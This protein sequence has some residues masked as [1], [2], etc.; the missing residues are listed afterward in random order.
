MAAMEFLMSPITWIVVAI[1]FIIGNIGLGI[2]L[3]VIFRMT[4]AKTELK[5]FF[6]NTPIGMF[7]QD[8]RFLDWRPVTP[9]NGIVYDERYGPFMVGKT[10]VS[11]KTKNIILPFDVDLDGDRTTNIRE[12]ADEFK[13]ISNNEKSIAML[14]TA[15]SS[16]E[17]GM[18]SE[19]MKKNVANLTS[20][21]KFGN[22]K[23]TLRSITPHSIKSKIE[24]LVSERMVKYGKVDTIQ[25][26]IIFGG[27]F[28]IIV[29]GTM[30]AKIMTAGK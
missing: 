26:V 8:N 29:I 16:E 13:N 27:I 9:I 25:A 21:L 3:F 24:K 18:S 1:L 12:I 28:G 7:F 14:R 23:Q 10:Y 20:T 17:L 4:H 2:L 11:K 6:T 19:S 30:I 5:A 15:I 22:L